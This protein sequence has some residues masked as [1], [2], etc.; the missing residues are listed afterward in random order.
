G[1]R[2]GNAGGGRVIGVEYASPDGAGRLF[3]D[4][5]VACDGRSSTV[6]RAVGLPT[7]EIPVGL[8]VWW[9]RVPTTRRIGESLFPRASAGR[10]AVVIPREGYLQIAQI[11]RK[12]T[13]ADVRARGIAAFRTE[14]AEL[15]PEVADE[16][17]GI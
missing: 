16:V 12:G 1:D 4:L 15:L 8:D 3:A 11:G 7:K 10:V 13:D 14:V 9:Y 6:R 17:S 2:D 5:T